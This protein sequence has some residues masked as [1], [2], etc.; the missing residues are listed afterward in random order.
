MLVRSLSH[1]SLLNSKLHC[2]P[3]I[4]NTN[5]TRRPITFTK[6]A[7]PA[8]RA[9]KIVKLPQQLKWQ[10]PLQ[11]CKMISTS[12]A[13]FMKFKPVNVRCKVTLLLTE[14]S[15]SHLVALLN[16]QKI[17]FYLL[18]RRM[19]LEQVLTRTYFSSHS[20]IKQEPLPG[21]ELKQEPEIILGSGLESVVNHNAIIVSRS[22]VS[23]NIDTIFFSCKYCQLYYKI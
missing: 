8:F 13:P 14:N 3:N 5:V 20:D 17:L 12:K 11:P 1:R 9:T 16:H 4:L 7:I 2:S 15:L 19:K 6:T 21:T 10:I 22:I 18:L 23:K